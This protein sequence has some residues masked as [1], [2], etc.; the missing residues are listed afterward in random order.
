VS[1]A[2]GIPSVVA[3]MTDAVE[4]WLVVRIGELPGSIPGPETGYRGSFFMVFLGPSKKI[5]ASSSK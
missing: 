2:I 1:S 4:T 5:L 3:E